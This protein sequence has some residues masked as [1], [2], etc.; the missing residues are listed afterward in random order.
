MGPVVL[1]IL[2]GGEVPI[3]AV[4]GSGNVGKHPHLP[5]GQQ[6]IRNG[7]AEHGGVPLDVKAVHQSQRAILI[8]GQFPGKEASRLLPELRRALVDNR[9]VVMIVL[10][11]VL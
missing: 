9:L 5:R 11:H 10:V 3:A 8:F 2:S 1:D 7:N 4:K 6:S